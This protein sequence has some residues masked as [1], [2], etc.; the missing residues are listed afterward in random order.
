MRRQRLRRHLTAKTPA[1][2]TW[3]SS[4]PY[5][6]R[7]GLA[8]PSRRAGRPGRRRSSLADAPPGNGADPGDP[9]EGSVRLLRRPS[10]SSVLPVRGRLIQRVLR[11]GAEWRAPGREPSPGG[12]RARSAARRSP[13]PARRSATG[14]P[15]SP[16]AG[17]IPAPWTACMYASRNSSRARSSIACPA[18]PTTDAAYAERSEQPGD[19]AQ[20]RLL[21][22]SL[23]QR[24]A[25]SPSKSITS[26][27]S[28]DHRSWPRWRSPWQ[29]M[30]RPIEP[31]VESP[32]SRSRTASARPTR[33]ATVVLR[34]G[35][36]PGRSPRPR[37]P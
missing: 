13:S 3:S 34:Q 24:R 37:S 33:G 21:Q 17:R 31:T 2:C 18:T 30:R 9:V 1:G 7:A 32:R 15:P 14:A 12:S 28:C 26:Q 35:G 4:R 16:R 5:R 23:G 29:R 22:P 36:T 19:V 8:P 11:A 27:S 6:P 20:R 25:G 10:A